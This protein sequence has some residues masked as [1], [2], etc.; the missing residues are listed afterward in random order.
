[1]TCGEPNALVVV[2]S[3]S[4]RQSSEWLRSAV[5]FYGQHT[6]VP[7]VI[8]ESAHRVE[9]ANK[10]RILSLPSSEAA[11]RGYAKCKLLILDE[12]SRIEDD[13]IAAARPSIALGGKHGGSI[14]ALSTPNGRKGKFFEWW[15]DGGDL[16]DRELVPVEQCTR[17]D[18]LFLQEE[19]RSLGPTMYSQE[20]QCRFVDD[21][22]QAFPTE[23]F[24]RC[25]KPR[26]QRLWQ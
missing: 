19:L 17:I 9:F 11:V 22:E 23:L 21:D 7:G 3:P 25:F 6:N 5:T 12:C 4:Q 10:S 1:V 18:P 16:W 15:Q 2:L 13:I 26:I 8:A 24:E 14:I 20:Y